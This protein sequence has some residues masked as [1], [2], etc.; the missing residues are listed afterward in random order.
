MARIRKPIEKREQIQLDQDGIISEEL[1]A[2][3]HL[4]PTEAHYDRAAEAVGLDR[5]LVP[6][7][8]T[9]AELLAFVL[10]VRAAGGDDKAMAAILDR[11]SPK[12]SRNS[13]DI[14]VSSGGSPVTS[15]SPEE[16]EAAANYMRSL[17]AV[18]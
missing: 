7:V 3:V 13:T 8:A 15:A 4:P 14:N 18:P 17:Q 1:Q 2:V 16:A 9:V 6:H 10:S 12:A 11:F 5:N